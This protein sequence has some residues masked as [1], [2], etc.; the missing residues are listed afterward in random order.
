M[1]GGSYYASGNAH[2]DDA[3]HV[4]VFSV[5]VCAEAPAV[6]DQSERA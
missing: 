4:P 3:S 1:K 6:A 5:R 2:Q